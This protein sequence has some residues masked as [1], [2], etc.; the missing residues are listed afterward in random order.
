MLLTNDSLDVHNPNPMDVRDLP[1]YTFMMYQRERDRREQERMAELD[2]YHST[3]G[4]V[5]TAE[6]AAKNDDGI[7]PKPPR[8]PCQ[9]HVRDPRA[10]N[11]DTNDGGSA[12]EQQGPAG[13]VVSGSQQG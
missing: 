12:A 3:I 1:A 6:R 4:H 7:L 8:Y 9:L 10:G 11:P 5:M 13:N 2:Q